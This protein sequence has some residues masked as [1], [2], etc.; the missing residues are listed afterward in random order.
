M[1]LNIAKFRIVVSSAPALDAGA[2]PGSGTAPVYWPSPMLM[3][4]PAQPCV[5]TH[6]VRGT[7]ANVDFLTLS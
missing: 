3:M 5:V 4:N 6:V 2:A 7:P 1:L